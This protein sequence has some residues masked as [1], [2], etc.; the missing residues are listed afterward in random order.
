MDQALEG[1]E[2]IDADYNRHCRAARELAEA[3]FDARKVLTNLIERAV[4]GS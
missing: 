3:S 1:M 4:S 2:A